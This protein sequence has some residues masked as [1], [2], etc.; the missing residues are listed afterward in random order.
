MPFP[1]LL[2]FKTGLVPSTMHELISNAVTSCLYIVPFL[3]SS[4]C[5]AYPIT[6]LGKFLKNTA[7]FI[8]V[9]LHSI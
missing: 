4:S 6:D 1:V 8:L 7:Q 5:E 2:I 9:E 3:L